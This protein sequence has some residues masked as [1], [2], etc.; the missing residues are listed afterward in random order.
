MHYL[1]EREDE[2]SNRGKVS[3]RSEICPVLDILQKGLKKP[4]GLKELR[5]RAAAGM[6]KR[7]RLRINKEIFSCLQ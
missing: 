2:E 1:P 7:V 5:I 4:Q 3:Y 6:Y